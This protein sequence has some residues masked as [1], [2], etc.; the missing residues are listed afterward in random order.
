MANANRRA[1]FIALLPSGT[2]R[3]ISIYVALTLKLAIGELA[4]FVAERVCYL[5]SL[6][7]LAIRKSFIVGALKACLLNREKVAVI[8]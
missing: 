3:T 8:Q 4:P 6:R 2:G 7:G 5:P 1:G